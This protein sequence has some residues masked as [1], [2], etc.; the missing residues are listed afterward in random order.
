MVSNPVRF[1]LALSKNCLHL[2]Q[3]KSYFCK[4]RT[5]KMSEFTTSGKVVAGTIVRLKSGGLW[6]EA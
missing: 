3:I 6:K 5:E 2:R 1:N 4:F